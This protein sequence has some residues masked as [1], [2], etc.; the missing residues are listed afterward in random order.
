TPGARPRR[1]W[2]PNRTTSPTSVWPGTC[3]P[4]AGTAWPRCWASSATPPAPPW[5]EG[6]EPAGKSEAR[7]RRASSGTW[8]VRPGLFALLLLHVL[9]ALLGVDGALGGKARFQAL[10]AD[11]LAG[12]HAVAVVAGLQALERAVDLADELAVAVAGA[13]FQRILGLA[14]RAFVFVADVAHSLAPVL[15]GLLGFLDQ[16]GAPVLQAL[17]EVLLLQ[18]AHVLL[19]RRGLVAGRQDRAAGRLVGLVLDHLVLAARRRGGRACG[20]GN[21]DLADRADGG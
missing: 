11:L 3:R 18:R 2:P 1:S 16:V 13:Q 6:R 12:V 21:G 9:P 14:G 17:A 8:S 20:Y 7:R 5:P 19:V 15:D 4:P 10:Q